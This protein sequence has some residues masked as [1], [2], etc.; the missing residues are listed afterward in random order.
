MVSVLFDEILSQKDLLNKVFFDFKLFFENNKSFFESL[1]EDFKT[2]NVYFIGSGSSFNIAFFSKKIFEN[3]FKRPFFS[4]FSSEFYNKNFEVKNSLIFVFSQSGLTSDTF[5]AVKKFSDKNFNNKFVL[6]SNNVNPK[7]FYDFLI[8]SNVGF[9]NAVQSTKTFT[10]MLYQVLLLKNFFEDKN[11]KKLN[12]SYLFEKD[13]LKKLELVSKKL[14]LKKNFI[15]LGFDEFYALSLEG[16]LKFKEISKSNSEAYSILEF[17]HGYIEETFN[18][19]DFVIILDECKRN[20]KKVL[21]KVV[22]KKYDKKINGYNKKYG[23]DYNKN[24]NKKYSGVLLVST[25]KYSA[26][27]LENFNNPFFISV[28]DK[29]ISKIIVLQFLSYFIA[30]NKGFNPDEVFKIKKT[31]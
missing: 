18:S 25:K 17:F 27:E 10:S 9:E 3:T 24:Y 16:S 15:F 11:F 29:Y 8:P 21:E 14:F 12:F 26:F 19:E 31:I 13:F 1:K 20:T 22:F 28:K 7:I 5:K 2:K 6:F 4:F 30:K 23:E